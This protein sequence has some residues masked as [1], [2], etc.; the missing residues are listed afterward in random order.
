MS[1]PVA[2]KQIRRVRLDH[3]TEFFPRHSRLKKPLCVITESGDRFRI[4]SLAEI[5]RQDHVLCADLTYLSGEVLDTETSS[6]QIDDTML[7][8]G[9]TGDKFLLKF[10]IK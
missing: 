2:A 4:C 7:Q 3:Q 6:D 1:L 10:Q 5:R 9:A 8:I